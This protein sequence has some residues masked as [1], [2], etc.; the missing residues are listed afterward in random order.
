M[1]NAFLLSALGLWLV[2]VAP[3]A[4]GQAEDHAFLP[5][6]QVLSRLLEGNQRFVS[7]TSKHP[8]MTHQWRDRL[9]KEQHPVAVILGCSDSRVPVEM[10]FDQGFGDLFVVRVAG[11]IVDDN[12]AAS[13]VYG[14][15]HAG[16]SLVLVLGHEQCGAVTSALGDYRA[17][18]LSVQSLLKQIVP[19]L[20]EIG[21][22]PMEQRVHLG[23]EANARQTVRELSGLG[24]LQ[25]PLK[26]G[27]VRIV[28]GVYRLETGRVELLESESK[29]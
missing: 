1:R 15:L 19:A 11:N 7:D 12:I 13:V 24:S 23:V 3:G 22:G 9:T 5:P 2:V 27:R 14:V 25:E 20:V 21:P 10:V 29:P 28:G 16:A 4:P 18:P 8:H 17:E 26:T 6:D